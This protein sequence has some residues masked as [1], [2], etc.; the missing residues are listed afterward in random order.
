VGEAITWTWIEMVIGFFVL[1]L[2]FA[3]FDC[4]CKTKR[5]FVNRKAELDNPEVVQV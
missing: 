2:G 5:E 1:M 4:I 3:I